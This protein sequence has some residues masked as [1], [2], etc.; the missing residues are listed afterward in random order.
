[1]R[2]LVFTARV[3]VVA[4]CLLAPLHVG[5][6]RAGTPDVQGQTPAS[7]A[8]KS[9]AEGF[10]HDTGLG[11][12]VNRGRAAELYRQAAEAGHI[13]A[14]F[15]LAALYLRGDGVPRDRAEAYKWALLAHE[16]NVTLGPSL[17]A[18]EAELK[19]SEIAEGKRRAQAWKRR[20]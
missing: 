18:I 19:A 16:Q 14:Q 20:Q 12:P 15:H 9:F 13:E 17:E 7:K 5:S 8:M 1:M 2:S 3:L 10:K 4:G 6:S 11:G